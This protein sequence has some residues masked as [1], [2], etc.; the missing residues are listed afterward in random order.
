LGIASLMASPTNE[1]MLDSVAT[2]SCVLAPLA[3]MLA[4]TLRHVAVEVANDGVR[5]GL[6]VRYGTNTGRPQGGVQDS[7]VEL[8]VNLLAHSSLVHS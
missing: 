8:C 1:A 2:G 6:G 7:K 3:G 5:C 4:G